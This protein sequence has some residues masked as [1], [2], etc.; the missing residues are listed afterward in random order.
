MKGA[1]ALV[2]LLA[3]ACKEEPPAARRPDKPEDTPNFEA[4]FQHKERWDAEKKALVIEM[5]IAP[6][7]HAYTTGEATGKPLA[8]ELAPDSDLV[9]TGEI[10][11]PK[12]TVKDL[13]L[14]RSVI[15][16]GAA[17]IVAPVAPKEGA[18][19]PPHLK[20]TLRYQICTEK[21]CDRPRS[22]KFDLTAS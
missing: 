10:E 21:A 2:L 19:S 1:L 17:Q 5:T 9:A 18:A 22:M 12:G 13:S 4:A 7:F 16:E 20:G 11:Y 3:S 14:G 8:V 6:G 15:V